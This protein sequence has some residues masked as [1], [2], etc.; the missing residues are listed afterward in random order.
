MFRNLPQNSWYYDDCRE[1]SLY[2]SST[3][4]YICSLAFFCQQQDGYCMLIKSLCIYPQLIPSDGLMSNYLK[5]VL[6][7]SIF[8]TEYETVRPKLSWT[9]ICERTH[10][11]GENIFLI[12]TTRCSQI[13]TELHNHLGKV[14]LARKGSDVQ[15]LAFLFSMSLMFSFQNNHCS[16]SW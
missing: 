15:I 12:R 4:F 10:N 13:L 6:C 16:C 3:N 7:F 1:N 11:D 9:P 8:K 2:V 5:P 14:Y